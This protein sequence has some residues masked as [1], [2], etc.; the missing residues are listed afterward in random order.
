MAMRGKAIKPGDLLLAAPWLVHRNPDNWECPHQFDPDRFTPDAIKSRHRFAWMP[1]GAG[2]RIC[3]G[4]Q[5]ALLEAVAILGTLLPTLRL[6]AKP[7][8]VPVPISRVTTRPD[9]GM[10]MTV[11]RR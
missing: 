8:Y 6:R 10:P 1:F 4:M 3:I 7:G 9:Q 2:P 5:F 11:E